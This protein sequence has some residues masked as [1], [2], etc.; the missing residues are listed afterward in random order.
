MW[1]TDGEEHDGPTTD[2]EVKSD[3]DIFKVSDPAAVDEFFSFTLKRDT[4]VWFYLPAAR[5]PAHSFQ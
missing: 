1:W 5:E 4:T 2:R 3:A